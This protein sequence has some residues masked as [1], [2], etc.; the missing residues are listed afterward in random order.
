MESNKTRVDWTPQS[1]KHQ[2]IA[3]GDVGTVAT[4][5]FYVNVPEGAYISDVV[6]ATETA[7]SGNSA[8]INVKAGDS[9]DDDKFMTQ[10]TATTVGT[11]RFGASNSI[12]MKSAITTGTYK[13]QVKLSVVVGTG[14]PT[15][16]K[17]YWWVE[18]RYD[19]NSVWSQASLTDPS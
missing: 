9:G 7:F 17:L 6:V 14:A 2:A 1:T 3:F 18:Y 16:G 19:P 15:A 5:A 10:T 8:T 11:Y 12:P 4:H 13:N